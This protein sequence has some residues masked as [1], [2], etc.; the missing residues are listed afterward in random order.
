[1]VTSFVCVFVKQIPFLFR[2]EKNNMDAIQNQMLHSNIIRASVEN[3]KVL[4]KQLKLQTKQIEDLKTTV[5]ELNQ[6]LEDTTKKTE[7]AELKSLKATIRSLQREVKEEKEM[8]NSKTRT[9][10]HLTAK[11]TGLQLKN[12]KLENVLLDHK[13]E[14]GAVFGKMIRE[15]PCWSFDDRELVTVEEWIE[16]QHHHCCIP[17]PLPYNLRRDE[18]YF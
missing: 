8:Q 16:K 2:S 11:I 18:L 4:E 10:H 1:M 9:Y 6:K 7:S 12:K 14:A 3:V 13:R 17:P 15:N 5:H